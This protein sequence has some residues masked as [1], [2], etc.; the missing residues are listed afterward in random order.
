M[1][2]IRDL[3][4]FDAAVAEAERRGMEVKTTVEENPGKHLSLKE[5]P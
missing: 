5:Q 2:S 4:P 3:H 1:L